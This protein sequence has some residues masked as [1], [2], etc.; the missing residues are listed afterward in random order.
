MEAA[1]ARGR[2]TSWSQTPDFGVTF[3]RWWGRGVNV[4]IFL[5][6]RQTRG[7]CQFE[8]KGRADYRSFPK[9]FNRN[10]FCKGSG[11]EPGSW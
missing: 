5:W 9:S 6:G 1:A 11:A 2:A 4:P 8:V 3:C 7:R 10:T